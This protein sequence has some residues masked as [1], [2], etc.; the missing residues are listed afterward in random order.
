MSAAQWET[1]DGESGAV[2]VVHIDNSIAL[3]ASDRAQ[4]DVQIA[5]AKRWPRDLSKFRR[6]AM[7]LVAS[8]E[9]TAET[10]FYALPRKSQG[11]TTYIEGPSVRFA[12]ALVYCWG[13][14][15]VEA[16]IVGVDDTHV[17]A[18]GTCMD[19]EKNIGCRVEVKRRITGSNGRKYNEDMIVVTGNAAA[20]IAF[21]NAVFKVIPFSLAKSIYEQARKVATGGAQPIEARRQA[22][23]TWFAKVGVP[24]PRLLAHFELGTVDEITEEH[25][26][27]L[28]GLRNAIKEGDT[29]VEQAFPAGP[30]ANSG[31]AASLK[32]ELKHKPAE[33]AAPATATPSPAAASSPAPAAEGREERK[34]TAMRQAYEVALK[35]A[36][37]DLM[38]DDFDAEFERREFWQAVTGKRDEAELTTAD[39][40]KMIDALNA[41][42]EPGQEG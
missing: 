5:T 7:A 12:E 11:K 3:T 18:Q 22:A 41:P 38:G 29:S 35:S 21:R 36:R 2:E 14:L 20:S 10:M 8:D 4:I 24:E 26:L 16:R 9:G 32:D 28:T 30:D 6:D 34:R 33:P 42:R 13:N 1:S 15:R 17:T 39:Y 23:L 37:P 19:L 31:H 27:I 25:L 40:K